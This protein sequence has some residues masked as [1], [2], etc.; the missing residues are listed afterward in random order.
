[1]S[2]DPTFIQRLWGLRR[3]RR[4]A[5]VV[6]RRI[7]LSRFFTIHTSGIRLR[8]FPAVWCNILW[9]T[10]DYFRRDTGL[11]RRYLRPGDTVVDCGAN[12]G[13]LTLVS[14]SI[15]GNTGA[16]YAIEAHPRLARYLRSNVAFNDATNVTIFHNAVG[17]TEGTIAFSDRITDDSN[18][19]LPGGEGIAVTMKPLDALIPAG[20]PVRLLKLDVEGYEKF[21]LDGARALLPTVEAIYFESSDQLFARYGYACSDVYDLLRAAGFLIFRF[22]EEPRLERLPDDY[23]SREIENLIALRDAERFALDTGYEIV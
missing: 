16:V 2:G 9:E 23:E 12:V 7:G 8:F 11:L 21:A 15:V 18:H 3:P 4:L 20:T 1:M 19:I 17:D 22:G 14:A 13:L 5:S 6:L 10:P